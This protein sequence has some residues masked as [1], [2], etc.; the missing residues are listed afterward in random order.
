MIPL[1]ASG[2]ATV[3]GADEADADNIVREIE[4]RP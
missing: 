2:D 1:A 3:A 4:A